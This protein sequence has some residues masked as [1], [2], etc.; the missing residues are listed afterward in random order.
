MISVSGVRDLVWLSWVPHSG[1]F[2]RPKAR[3]PPGLRC[4]LMAQMGEDQ[5]LNPSCGLWWDLL[6]LGRSDRAPQCLAGCKPKAT[7]GSS[8]RGL[9]QRV[10]IFVKASKGESLLATWASDCLYSDHKSDISSTLSDLTGWKVVA[11]V[12]EEDLL[13]LDLGCH[14]GNN[15]WAPPEASGSGKWV[16]HIWR[17]AVLS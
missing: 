13:L 6:P 14:P 12:F 5:P 16:Y 10:D 7:F 11:S 15:V 8:S 2:T 3:C 4:H 17:L 1:L 9:L